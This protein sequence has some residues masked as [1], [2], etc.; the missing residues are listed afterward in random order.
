MLT[1]KR[2]KYLTALLNSQLLT[3]AFRTFYAG[4]DL[5]GN[6]FRYKKTF[7]EQLPIPKIEDSIQR[8]FESFVDLIQLSKINDNGVIGFV[9]QFLEDLIDA[10][11][12]E[13]FFT[14]H[15]SEKDLLVLDD[16]AGLINKFNPEASETE[17]LKFLEIFYQTANAPEHPI[18]NRLLRMTADSPDLLAVI[19]GNGAV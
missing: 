16:V 12:F 9:T 17:Q 3:Y 13:L 11:V 14:E 6:T 10:C 1:G 7:L 15:M 8:V 2:I 19:K 18:R 5:R 4:G